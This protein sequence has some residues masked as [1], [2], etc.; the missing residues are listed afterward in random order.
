MKNTKLII[1][2][3]VALFLSI[4]S[5]WAQTLKQ[6]KGETSFYVEYDEED[7]IFL[8]GY[9]NCTW[10]GLEDEMGN[11]LLN[12]KFEI[13]H[14]FGQWNIN[15]L[16][17]TCNFKNGKLDGPASI[18]YELEETNITEK[19]SFKDGKLHGAFSMD[20][21]YVDGEDE[22]GI[23]LYKYKK[24]KGLYNNGIMAGQYS[25]NLP[26]GTIS[27]TFD[28]EGYAKGVWFFFAQKYTYILCDI[29]GE[30]AYLVTPLAYA[31][32]VKKFAV[33]K[34][35]SFEM[36][37][38]KGYVLKNNMNEYFTEMHLK[39][40]DFFF[41]TMLKLYLMQPGLQ[42]CRYEKP[43]FTDVSIH[44]VYSI[45]KPDGD[46]M[47]E[48]L[49]K[50]MISKKN[51]PEFHPLECAYYYNKVDGY[52]P[53]FCPA[54]YVN[55]HDSI[56]WERN[57]ESSDRIKRDESS[58]VCINGEIIAIEVPETHE[59][60]DME[61]SVQ[62]LYTNPGIIDDF[63][64]DVAAEMVEK[65]ESPRYPQV[66]QA[67]AKQYYEAK[68]WKVDSVSRLSDNSYKAWCSTS[69]TVEGY[70][71]SYRK[72]ATFAFGSDVK[73]T[74]GETIWVEKDRDRDNLVKGYINAGNYKMNKN[75]KGKP[76]L[77]LKGIE[78]SL[79]S[80]EVA[81]LN[82]NYEKKC[83]EVA[84]SQM[85][86]RYFL[87]TIDNGEYYYEVNKEKFVISDEDKATIDQAALKYGHEIVQQHLKNRVYDFSNDSRG[88]YIME[89]GTRYYIST[90]DKL[91]LEKAY[92][93]RC[94]EVAMEM[95]NSYKYNYQLEDGKACYKVG[96]DIFY[97]SKEDKELIDNKCI[98]MAKE[99]LLNQLKVFSKTKADKLPEHQQGYGKMDSY[100][101]VSAESQ[102][103]SGSVVV[104]F[105]FVKKLS[106]KEFETYED[107]AILDYQYSPEGGS[108]TLNMDKSFNFV[109]SRKIN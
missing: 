68:N 6:K 76:Y 100:E 3:L 88:Y 12:G 2:A 24:V 33:D 83:H 81:R 4:E 11:S 78:I 48:A 34:T 87:Y 44:A 7:G 93:E 32:D 66:R 67:Y 80:A 109:K 97:L 52:T 5:L 37:K 90:N 10:N 8:P 49:Q 69:K 28:A 16:V 30:K 95:F 96:S 91:E 20:Q 21:S 47:S 42:R 92:Q 50:D 56:D 82:A 58:L 26:Q 99:P 13:R 70:T 19:L 27:G 108:F 23:L 54:N 18:S 65:G 25:N 35:L 74:E 89:K 40:S 107:K 29:N 57:Y 62:R 38:K 17:L 14:S 106:R 75:A 22:Y 1:F 94:H 77:V 63:V 15:G 41:L 46:V 102:M 39:K 71:A 72:S 43:V 101:I 105:R 104:T 53:I 55:Y 85:N 60:M 51:R 45:D 9:H 59:L 98:E 103:G 73:V 31:E 86:A 84:M 61:M 64:Q 36:L 79:S